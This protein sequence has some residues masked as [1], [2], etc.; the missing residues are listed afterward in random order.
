MV[1]P[2]NLQRL[3]PE[4]LTV[5]R[6]MQHFDAVSIAQLEGETELSNRAVGR[7]IRRLVN[8]DLIELQAGQ[9]QLTTDGKI[10]V[11]QLVEYEQTLIHQG[12][13]DGDDNRPVVVRRLAAVLP[14]TFVRNTP[15][16]IFLG[17]NP[18]NPGD[19]RLSQTVQ[20]D[21]RVSVVGGTLSA[22]QFTLN[23]PPNNAAAPVRF[24]L[25]PNDMQAGRPLR[26]RIDAFQA[27][28]VDESEPLGGMYMDINVILHSEGG[29]P[30]MRAVG[31]D[32]V[33][34]PPKRG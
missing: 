31:M 27:I 30:T 34:K 10:A 16:D 29:P 2:H 33:L 11:R 1:M 32:L 23:I 22:T 19:M 25:I 14:R 20:V 8:F 26:V 15:M 17:V 13:Q 21:L 7:A 24:R 18:P 12:P 3:P 28:D 4:A 9:Y 5:L 6:C